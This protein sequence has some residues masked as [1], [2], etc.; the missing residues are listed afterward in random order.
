MR[1]GAVM[2]S[3]QFGAATFGE[4]AGTAGIEAGSGALRCKWP[5]T[6]KDWDRVSCLR[7]ACWATIATKS[8]TGRV[9]CTRLCMLGRTSAPPA[10]PCV[11]PHLR[12]PIIEASKAPT[13]RAHA[14]S[15]VELVSSLYR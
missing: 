5:A 9:A 6:S 15:N 12:M 4:G 7:Q 13:S 8:K 2:R 3:D 11:L 1:G 10:L 14:R